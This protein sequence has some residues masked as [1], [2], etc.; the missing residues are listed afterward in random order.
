MVWHLPCSQISYQVF[1]YKGNS[2]SG[3]FQQGDIL[4]VSPASMDVARPGDVIAFSE[5][6]LDRTVIVHRVRSRT[7]GGLVT[8]GD[9]RL[10]GDA[11]LVYA[12]NLIGRVCFVQRNGNLRPVLGGWAGQLWVAY[13]RLRRWSRQW[14]RLPYRFLRASGIVKRLWKPCVMKVYFITESGP[15]VKYIHGRRTVACWSPREKQFWCRKPYDLV[16]KRPD[17]RPA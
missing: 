1:P 14:G 12:D 7:A 2:M 3:T 9:S 8:Q 11:E 15:L 5:R 6:R 16:I 4:L 17:R 13:L 10:T